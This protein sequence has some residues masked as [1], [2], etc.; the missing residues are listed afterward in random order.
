MHPQSAASVDSAEIAKFSALAGQWWD[1]RGPF[2]PLHKFNPARLTWIRDRIGAHFGRDRR[3]PAPF[4][5]LEMLDI[6]CGGGL[7]CEPLARLG[8]GMTGIDASLPNIEAARLH[9]ARMGLAIDYRPLAAETL[10]GTGRQFD[11]VLALETVEHV[12]DRSAFLAAVAA[13]LRPGGLALLATL[14]RTTR[15]FA[16]AI[17]GA[18]YVLG[19]VPRGTHDWR[20]FLKPA[21]LVAALRSVGLA[22][23]DRTGVCYAP[24]AGEWRLCDDLGVNYIVAAVHAPDRP[25]VSAGS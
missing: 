19:W 4:K 20:R 11:V 16:L 12:A 24:L 7:V 14:N 15:S 17:V 10:V 6:G 23:S 13:L 8:A 25:S 9:A 3:A 5:G 1:A 22:T 21:E 2:A 18:E